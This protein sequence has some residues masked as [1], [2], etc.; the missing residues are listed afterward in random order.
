M[1]RLS[2]RWSSLKHDTADRLEDL[3]HRMMVNELLEQENENAKIKRV[4]LITLAAIAIAVFAAGVAYAVYKFL[5]KDYLEDYE[6]DFDDD[7]LI[8][9]AETP[10]DED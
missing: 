8:E 3:K 2:E 4:I 10:E 1:D 9:D 6:D 7:F 5:S